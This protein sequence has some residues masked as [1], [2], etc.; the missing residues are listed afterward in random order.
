M[1]RITVDMCPHGDESKARPLG[2]MKIWNDV[3]GTREKGNYGF[4]ISKCGNAINQTWKEGEIKGFPRLRRNV[5][6]LLF[7]ALQNAMKDSE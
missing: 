3:T 1:I 5:W 4:R 7:R 2:I 6:Y